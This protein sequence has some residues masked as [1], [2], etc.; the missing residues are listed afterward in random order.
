MPE[1][2]HPLAS[3]LLLRTLRLNCLTTAYSEI[4]EELYDPTWPGYEPWAHDWQG[5]QPLHNVTP[6]WNRDTPLRTERARR[7]ALVEIDALVAVWLGVTADALV[8]MYKSRFPIMQDFDA[9]TWFDAGERKLAGDRYT[10]GFGQTKEHYEQFLAYN[11]G[12]RAEPPE[13]YTAPFYKANREEELRAAHAVFAER[14][15]KAQAK[16]A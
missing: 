5:L 16:Q 3:A 14:L 10:Y 13:G 2:D 9:V 6:E 15:R 7:A 1:V 8:A 4:W 11:K 12:E